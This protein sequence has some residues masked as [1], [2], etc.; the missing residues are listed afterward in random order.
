MSVLSSVSKR[1][2]K[3]VAKIMSKNLSTYQFDYERIKGTEDAKW[4]HLTGVQSMEKFIPV[5]RK[6]LLKKM[7]E[8]P[9]IITRFEIESFQK[10]ATGLDSMFARLYKEKLD[11][12]KSLYNPLSPDRDTV[13]MKFFTEKQLCARKN[14]ILEKLS[15]HL[16][17]AAFYKLPNDV[18]MEAIE[19]KNVAERL[20]VKVSPE[21]YDVL[22]F[23]VIGMDV[24]PVDERPWYVI[25]GEQARSLKDKSSSTLDPLFQQNYKRSFAVQILSR[26]WTKMYGKQLRR[27][28]RYKRVIVAYKLKKEATLQLKSLKDIACENL[29]FLLPDGKIRMGNLDKIRLSVQSLIFLL[30]ILATTITNL[31][32]LKLEMNLILGFSAALIF[33]RNFAMYKNMRNRHMLHMSQTLYFRSIANSHALLPLIIDRAEDETYKAALLICGIMHKIA[34]V[35]NESL[36]TERGISKEELKLLIE[37]WVRENFKVSIKFSTDNALERL[38]AWK[39]VTNEEINGMEVFKAVPFEEAL[40]QLPSFKR[41]PVLHHADLL[42]INMERTGVSKE[43]QE[44]AYLNY[45]GRFDWW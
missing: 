27:V 21:H 12:L 25:A 20:A 26:L 6:T 39:L 38:L 28:A 8:D 18:M 34:L 7:L 1:T 31:T 29:E 23:W 17:E 45:E 16:S 15:M 14:E 35:S 10:L 40:L 44:E 3:S 13:Q 32:E 36:Q 4:L 2:A 11:D 30:F 19:E 24:I 41:T 33:A 5:T 37:A 9:E 43:E 42:D 22:K